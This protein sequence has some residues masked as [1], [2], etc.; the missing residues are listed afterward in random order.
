MWQEPISRR[1]LLEWLGSGCVLALSGPALGACVQGGPKS[2]SFPGD[3]S[4]GDS[5]FPFSPGDA[6][7]PSFDGWTVYTADPQD[8][9][10]ILD[11]WQLTVDGLVETPAHYSFAELTALPRLDVTVDFHCVTGWS[12][13]DVPWNGVH[14]STLFEAAQPR[15]TATHVTFHTVGGVYNESI[16]IDVALE[17]HTL[18]GYG[19]AEGTLPLEHGF[20]ARLVVP[21]FMGYK[22]AKYVERIEL[23]DG[24]VQA[25]WETRGYPYDAE[26]PRA[27][28]RPGKY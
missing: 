21:R 28:L 23:T 15:P 16:P 20:P 27:R 10:Q 19:I 2:R 11:S 3:A 7:A 22:N 25:Y 14:L 12:V 1:S 8:L 24:P 6:T 9:Q 4:L 13:F 17:E 5:S 26:V 18:L